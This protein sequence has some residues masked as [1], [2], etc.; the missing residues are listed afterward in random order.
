MCVVS[1]PGRTELFEAMFFPGIFG[2]SQ[3]GDHPWEKGF[4]LFQF[5][6]FK[7]LVNFLRLH[8]RKRKKLIATMQ[9][10]ETLKFGR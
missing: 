7:S 3:S 8:T 9:N 6:G 2:Y 10:F 1:D 5:C 4:F